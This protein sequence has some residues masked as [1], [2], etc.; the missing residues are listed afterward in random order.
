MKHMRDSL[1]CTTLSTGLKK[2]LKRQVDETQELLKEQEEKNKLKEE[3]APIKDVK[4]SFYGSIKAEDLYKTLT[5]TSTKS[6]R[7]GGD[8]RINARV[9][10]IPPDAAVGIK[11]INQVLRRAVCRDCG[12][13]VVIGI[14]A[15]NENN[16][17][18]VECTIRGGYSSK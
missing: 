14:D 18:C 7:T 16:P 11:T 6:Q 3:K 8:G 5:V 9:N 13:G 10:L 4:K 1:P 15:V 2:A 12:K 17:R